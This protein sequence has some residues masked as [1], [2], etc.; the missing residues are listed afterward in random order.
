MNIFEEDDELLN[1]A[2]FLIC[3]ATAYAITLSSYA[4]FAACALPF[5]FL[6]KLSNSPIPARHR[7]TIFLLRI[8]SAHAASITGLVLPSVCHP[9]VSGLLDV[10]S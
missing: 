3:Q 4:P 9:G 8:V 6:I 2:Y 10:L 1:R 7:I 5:S